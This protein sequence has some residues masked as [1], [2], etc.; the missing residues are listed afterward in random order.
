VESIEYL[1]DQE[2]CDLFIEL[3]PGQVLAGLVSR[4]RKGTQVLSIS[5]L[6]SLEKVLPAI[7]ASR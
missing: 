5:N 1:I 6:E 4:I 7:R 3:G 2:R